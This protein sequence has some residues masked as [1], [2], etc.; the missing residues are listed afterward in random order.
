MNEN[1]ELIVIGMMLILSGCYLCAHVWFSQAFYRNREWKRWGGKA[2]MFGV[3]LSIAERIGGI[4]LVKGSF[5]GMGIL[6]VA[7]GCWVLSFLGGDIGS[8]YSSIT[9]YSF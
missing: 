9:F 7:V 2:V 6:S 5:L 3:V 4:Y 8:V 1:T